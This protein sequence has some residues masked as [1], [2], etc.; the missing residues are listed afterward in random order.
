MLFLY[1]G[2]FH[3]QNGILG[4][5]G[6]GEGEASR[7]KLKDASCF[8]FSMTN[9]TILI[10]FRTRAQKEYH[11]VLE[12]KSTLILNILALLLFENLQ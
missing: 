9:V 5:V 2:T 3:C 8:I 10:I 4:Q 6:V 11:K 12:I 1:I 7:N